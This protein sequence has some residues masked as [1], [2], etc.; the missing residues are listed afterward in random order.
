MKW[1]DDDGWMIPL[2]DECGQWAE[3]EDV[4]GPGVVYLGAGG[5]SPEESCVC[6]FCRLGVENVL[7]RGA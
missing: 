5:E 1:E 7:V 4:V 6:R 2:C 3:Q